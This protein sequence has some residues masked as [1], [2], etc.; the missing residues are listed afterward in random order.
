MGSISYQA[1]PSGEMHLAVQSTAAPPQTAPILF[2]NGDGVTDI[3][4]GSEW[5]DAAERQVDPAAAAAARCA[6]SCAVRTA[7]GW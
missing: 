5:D 4:V 6:A 3:A 7:A 2:L 1:W